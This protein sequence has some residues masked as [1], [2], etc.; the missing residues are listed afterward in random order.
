MWSSVA[1]VFLH[2]VHKLSQWQPV[3]LPRLHLSFGSLTACVIYM[4]NDH[5]VDNMENVS[6]THTNS[7]LQNYFNYYMFR[8]FEMAIIS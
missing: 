5:T 7:L 1:L 6:S 8:P 3:I 4:M 2:S